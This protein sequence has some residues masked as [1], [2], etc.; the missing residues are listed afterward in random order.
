MQK[1]EPE[2]LRLLAEILT[3]QSDGKSLEFALRYWTELTQTAEKDSEMWWA[4]REGIFEV[5]CNS[6][7]REEAKKEFETLRILYPDLGGV[8]RKE[9]LSRRF[10]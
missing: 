10:D 3:R 2:T 1:R 9:R 5:L 7:R 8:E 6:N 4:A